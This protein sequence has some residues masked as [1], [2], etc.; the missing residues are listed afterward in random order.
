MG[1]RGAV[2][3]MVSVVIDASGAMQKF[4]QLATL[5]PDC[6]QA[7]SVGAFDFFR[8]YHSKMTWRGSR[9]IPGG[10]S[11]QF[12]VNVVNGWQAPAVAG[13]TATVANTFELLAWKVSGGTIRPVRAQALAIP[14]VSEAKGV[15]PRTFGNLFIAGSALVRQV[16]KQLEAVYALSRSVTQAPWP[17]ALPDEADTVQAFLDGIQPVLTAAS[18]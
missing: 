6:L 10:N 3:V 8:D 9:W 15:P 17:G 16:G 11:G 14:L 7:G 1:R 4:N 13:N 5:V 2:L 18:A 12:A